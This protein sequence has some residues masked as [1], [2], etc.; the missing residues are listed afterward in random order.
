M[1][2]KYAVAYVSPENYKALSIAR[3][4]GLRLDVETYAP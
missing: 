3:R 1:G 4:M 2:F